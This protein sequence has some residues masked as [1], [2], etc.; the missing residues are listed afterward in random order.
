MRKLAAIVGGITIT[1]VAAACSSPSSTTGTE[2][3][4]GTTTN[5]AASGNPVIPLKATGVFT[6]T[7]SI[8][9]DNG[10]PTGT[11]GLKF[12]KGTL[13]L[14]H[15]STNGIQGTQSFDPKSC[16]FTQ[17][18][19]GTF[20]VV[21]G[22]TGSLKGYTGSGT[23]KVNFV[24]KFALVKGACPSEAALQNANPVSGLVTFTAIGKLTTPSSGSGY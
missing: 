11:D 8:T 22:S 18:N 23:Y 20:K 17:V 21:P 19:Q 4:T 16:T 24:G 15:A 12:S 10:G 6:D 5:I 9:L 7:G 14:Y 1:V 3:I 13:K 2:T